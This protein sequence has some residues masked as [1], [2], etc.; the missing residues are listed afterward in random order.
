MHNMDWPAQSPDLNPM[1]NLWHELGKKIENKK[2]TNLDD[3]WETVSH[4]W[5]QISASTSQNLMHYM[6]RRID[7]V[8]KAGGGHS[9]LKIMHNMLNVINSENK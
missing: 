6:F 7:A 4:C 8:I 2:P 5:G 3:S 9:S 1:E